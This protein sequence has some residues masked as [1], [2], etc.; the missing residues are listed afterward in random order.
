[1]SGVNGGDV[2]AYM[3]SQLPNGQLERYPS[4]KNSVMWWWVEDKELCE[5]VVNAHRGHRQTLLIKFLD[6]IR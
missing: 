2:S 5:G 3:N 4:F 6:M 1:M